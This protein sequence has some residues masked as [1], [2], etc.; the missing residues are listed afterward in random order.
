MPWYLFCM[1]IERKKIKKLSIG[2]AALGAGIALGS[3]IPM[4]KKETKEDPIASFLVED[5]GKFSERDPKGFVEDR[6][7]EPK[8]IANR[9]DFS[10]LE[11]DGPINDDLATSE[12]AEGAGANDLG[13]IHIMRKRKA[14]AEE[15]AARLAEQARKNWERERSRRTN[16][17]R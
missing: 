15:A 12:L 16:N 3:Q 6:R 2:A 5:K 17:S 1:G 7:G 8:D 11:P 4:E 14:L 9:L 13:P 10:E